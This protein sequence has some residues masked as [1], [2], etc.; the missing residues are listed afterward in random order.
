[1]LV[2]AVAV[3]VAVVDFDKLDVSCW[4]SALLFGSW[5]LPLRV[6]VWSGSKLSGFEVE[7][8]DVLCWG[9][10]GVF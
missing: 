1:M 9:L 3:V 10:G 4:D 8:I 2:V 6:A 7:N 5:M